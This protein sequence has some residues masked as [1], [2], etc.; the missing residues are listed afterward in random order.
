MHETKWHCWL[1]QLLPGVIPHNTVI[2][3]SVI[4]HNISVI[5]YNIIQHNVGVIQYNTVVI[6]H[7]VIL[8]NISV[9]QHNT[10]TSPPFKKKLRYSYF[11]VGCMI[12]VFILYAIHCI[13]HN[14]LHCCVD[15]C[16]VSKLAAI[17]VPGEVCTL[18]ISSTSLWGLAAWH[19]GLTTG[20]V[21]AETGVVSG[22]SGWC[23]GTTFGF[24]NLLLW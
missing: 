13:D 16:K 23:C 9:I 2:Q 12:L 24:M 14:V 18:Q 10:V 15:F 1:L 22:F 20:V 5:Q 11:T 8:H 4:Q 21:W 6:L 17:N 3:Y 19:C 7:N